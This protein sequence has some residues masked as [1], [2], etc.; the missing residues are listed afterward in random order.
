MIV[1]CESCQTKFNFNDDLLKSDG[2]KVKCSRCGNVFLIYPPEPIGET[3]EET[4]LPAG[5]EDLGAETDISEADPGMDLDFDD[6]FEDDIMEDFEDLE[7]DY[8]SDPESFEESTEMEVQYEDDEEEF[9]ER[10]EEEKETIPSVSGKKKKG[11][12]HILLI[13]CIIVLGLIGLGYGI[14]KY[15]PNLVPDFNLSEEKPAS[16]PKSAD[17][18]AS[19]LEILTVDGSFVDSEKAGRLFVVSGKVSNGYPK[20]R[21]FILVKGCILDDMGQIVKEK[22]AF[23]GNMLSEEELISMPLEKVGN[24]MKNRYGIDKK[25]IN[26]TSGTSVDFMIVFENLPDNLTEFTVGAVSSSPGSP[27]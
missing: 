25:N 2:S 4:D 12:S 6:N 5:Q 13:S 18:G 16:Q 3:L 21:S 11:K 15:F 1:Q 19:R 27:E 23:A 24:V 8:H 17:A 26:V 14:S 20:S 9:L 22:T 10:V 7:S